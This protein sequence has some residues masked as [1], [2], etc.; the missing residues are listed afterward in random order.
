MR[1]QASQQKALRYF[2]IDFSEVSCTIAAN[3]Y[4]HL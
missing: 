4:F 2:E 1:L 3:S